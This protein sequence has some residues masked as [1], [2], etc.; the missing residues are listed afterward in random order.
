MQFGLLAG[1]WWLKENGHDSTQRRIATYMGVDEQMTGQ[2]AK[3]LEAAG[4]V[5]REPRPQD[6]RAR[7]VILTAE[8]MRVLSST[9]D[10]MVQIEAEFFGML[11]EKEDAV[12]DGLR[13]IA[14]TVYEIPSATGAI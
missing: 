10:E 9:A 12:V 6:A 14:R 4:L 5:R 13:L 11:G 3:R 7:D 2:V 8:G 1:A